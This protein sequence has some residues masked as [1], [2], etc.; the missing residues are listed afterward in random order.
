[1]IVLD[2]PFALIEATTIS[3]GTAILLNL[4]AQ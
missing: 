1:M 4:V 2:V 3:F